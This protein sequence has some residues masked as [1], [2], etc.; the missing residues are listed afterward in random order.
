MARINLYLNWLRESYVDIR[1]TPLIE[2]GAIVRRPT[3][4]IQAIMEGVG[5]IYNQATTQYN[6]EQGPDSI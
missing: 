1:Q 4:A 2:N 3:D 5:T 6:K